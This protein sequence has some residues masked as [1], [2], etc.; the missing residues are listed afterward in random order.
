MQPQHEWL[1]TKGLGRPAAYSGSPKDH[2][3][4]E[5]S[6]KGAPAQAAKGTIHGD[7]FLCQGVLGAQ[8]QQEQAD[9]NSTE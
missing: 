9:E 2:P 7:A 4:S 6:V 5:D 3:V 8:Q 1:L